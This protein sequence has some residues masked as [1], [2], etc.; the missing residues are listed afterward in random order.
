[1]RRVCQS[2]YHLDRCSWSARRQKH[3]AEGN[4][5]LQSTSEHTHCSWA[6]EPRV[7]IL[8]RQET[9]AQSSSC[10]GS[11][12]CHLGRA[13]PPN[14]FTKDALGTLIESGETLA[15]GECF[16]TLSSVN[17]IVKLAHRLRGFGLKRSQEAQWRW[18]SFMSPAQLQDA[19]DERVQ[20]N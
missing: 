1:M 11:R 15:S 17:P 10:P 5:A 7:G 2:K 12:T 18:L 6:S 13:G 20:P 14:H 16:N 19:L 9:T 4:G 3:T 8:I